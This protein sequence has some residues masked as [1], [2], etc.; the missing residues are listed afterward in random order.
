[1][2]LQALLLFLVA[3]RASAAEDGAT[4]QNP[5]PLLLVSFDGFRADYLRRFPM[6]NLKLL[7]S[8]GVLVEEL[9]N[10][11]ITKTFPNHYTLVEPRLCYL[12]SFLSHC[13]EFILV[14]VER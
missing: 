8:Q 7:Y 10:V 9:T 5:P 2:L 3:V 1:M 11:F 14:C 12:L 13:L 6:P 4:R